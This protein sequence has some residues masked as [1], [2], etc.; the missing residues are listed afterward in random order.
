MTITGQSSLSKDAID[1]MVKDAEAHAEEDRQRR[2][3][4]DI[5]NSAD[6]LVYQ[7]EKLLKE[8]GD[9]ISDEERAN[10]ETKLADL[11]TAIS[12]SELETI[13]SATESLMTAS[14]EFTQKLYEQAAANESTGAAGAA[15]GTS[16]APRD[17]EVVDA[18]IVDDEGN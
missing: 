11:K 14:Q 13:K 6:S 2:E 5:R 9:K 16:S 1:Q 7:T 12:G 15:G 3:E 18:E 10:V 4:A 17:D 8:Q